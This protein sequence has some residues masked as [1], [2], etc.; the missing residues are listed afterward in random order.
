MGAGIV[1]EQVF[2][3]GIELVGDCLGGVVAPVFPIGIIPVFTLCFAVAP[4]ACAV[5]PA[6]QQGVAL[7]LGVEKM[8]QLQMRHLQQ[9]D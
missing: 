1:W 6:F 3:R 2:Q 9:P 8:R 7:D 5:L 4:F